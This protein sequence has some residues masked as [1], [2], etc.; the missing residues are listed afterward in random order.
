MWEIKRGNPICTQSCLNRKCETEE[1]K[2]VK[3]P[4]E[5]KSSWHKER[6][7]NTKVSNKAYLNII[8][9]LH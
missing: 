2:K 3:Y 1:K 9:Q 6:K 4:L 8:N 7:I 5:R